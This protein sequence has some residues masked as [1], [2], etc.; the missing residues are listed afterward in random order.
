MKVYFY[1]QKKLTFNDPYPT[2]SADPLIEH[3]YLFSLSLS[4]P[5][6]LTEISLGLTNSYLALLQMQPGSVYSLNPV[7]VAISIHTP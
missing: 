7:L 1:H 5:E 2:T 3:P 4:Y 6:L